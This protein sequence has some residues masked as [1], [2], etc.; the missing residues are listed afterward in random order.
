MGVRVGL[1]FL[2]K[3]PKYPIQH[4][5]EGTELGLEP[6]GQRERVLGLLLLLLHIGFPLLGPH[7]WRRRLGLLLAGVGFSARL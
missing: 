2:L 3:L 7:L 6:V 4:R 1:Q 5:N